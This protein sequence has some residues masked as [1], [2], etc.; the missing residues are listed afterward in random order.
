MK[1]VS[2]NLCIVHLKPTHQQF[3]RTGALKDDFVGFLTMLSFFGMC[4]AHG[5]LFPGPDLFWGQTFSWKRNFRLVQTSHRNAG[6]TQGKPAPPCGSEAVN[7]LS[8]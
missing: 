7:L 8:H 6:T 1:S 3:Q 2:V 4:A 5:P